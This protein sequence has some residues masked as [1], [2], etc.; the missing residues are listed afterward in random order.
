MTRD[1][2]LERSLERAIG[3]V[4][5][6]SNNMMLVSSQLVNSSKVTEK[7]TEA[8]RTTTE[9]LLATKREVNDALGPGGAIDEM[10][11][12]VHSRL[13]IVDTRLGIISNDVGIT[14][15]A[16]GTHRLVEQAD[17]KVS[18]LKAFGDLRLA[19]QIIVGLVVVAAPV[20]GALVHWL[21]TK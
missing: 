21:A 3:A 12:S 1:D 8:L 5:R 20:A 19:T 10:I 17:S 7:Q 14:R 11:R 4:E 2:A 9:A 13:G 18:L 6:A 15:E 16:T